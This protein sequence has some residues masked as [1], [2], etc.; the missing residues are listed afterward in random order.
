[1]FHRGKH[2]SVM[3]LLTRKQCL[4]LGLKGGVGSICLG[5][6]PAEFLYD[7]SDPGPVTHFA[8]SGKLRAEFGRVA[9]L[10]PIGQLDRDLGKVPRRNTELRGES[11]G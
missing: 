1:M 11:F 8:R 5:L 2:D 3:T 10:A 7:G 9:H 6:E 4:L